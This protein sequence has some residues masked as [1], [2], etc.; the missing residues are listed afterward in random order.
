MGEKESLVLIRSGGRQHCIG[1]TGETRRFLKA[2][3]QWQ[4]SKFSPSSQYIHPR[5]YVITS[6]RDFKTIASSKHFPAGLCKTTFLAI[7][8][9]STTSFS[10]AR[11]GDRKGDYRGFLHAV[12]ADFDPAAQ[13]SSSSTTPRMPIPKKQ[14]PGYYGQFKIIDQLL[15]TDLFAMHVASVS[16][17]FEDYWALAAQHPWAVYVGP[18]TGVRRRIWREMKGGMGML[19]KAEKERSDSLDGGT[20]EGG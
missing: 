6:Y 7:T 15:W 4:D 11:P 13:L 5:T 20:T 14:R 2:I 10:D 9:N 3:W 17:T 19:L 1:L 8:P 16:H 12:A 18:T